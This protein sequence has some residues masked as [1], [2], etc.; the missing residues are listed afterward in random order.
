MDDVGWGTREQ[1][2]DAL[3]G[4]RDSLG[5]RVNQIVLVMDPVSGEIF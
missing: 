4:V 1:A 3:V 2:L 5:L